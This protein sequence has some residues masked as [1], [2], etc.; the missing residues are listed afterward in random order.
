MCLTTSPIKN[1]KKWNWDGDI[2]VHESIVP[3]CRP[4]IDSRRHY[5]VDVREFLVSERNVVMRRT[6]E[7]DIRQLIIEQQGDAAFFTSRMPGSFDY[8]AAMIAEFVSK[9]IKYER[10]DEIDPWQFPEETLCL[11]SGDCEDRALLL[12]SLML[13]SGIS[14][15]NVRVCLGK[16]R[17]YFKRPDRHLDCDHVWVMYKS[18]NGQWQVIE[19]ANA[20]K[21]NVKE[22]PKD[23]PAQAEYIPYFMFNNTH[24]WQVRRDMAYDA[25]SVRLGKDWSRLHPKFAGQFHK[26]IL[27]DA[28]KG[29]TCPSWAL[30]LLNQHFTGF[31]SFTVDDVDWPD[32]YDPREHFDNGYIAEGW[33]LVN[34]R[35]TQF[36]KDSRANLGEFHKAAHTIADF[37]AH[38][39]YAH[40]SKRNPD[41]SLPIFDPSNPISALKGKP[42][43]DASQQFD[44]T[45]ENLFSVNGTLWKGSH[46]DAAE[47]WAGKI[48]S[49]RYGQRK[50]SKGWIEMTAFIPNNMESAKDFYLRAALPHHNEIAVDGGSKPDEHLLYPKAEFDRQTRLRIDV[51]TRHIRE[52]FNKN[53][54]NLIS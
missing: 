44:L 22:A 32:C 1:W 7:T 6:L 43:Y 46:A 42:V 23:L 29:T 28:L 45:K 2:I 15:Y 12:A 33:D 16:M 47:A 13:C 50:D 26:T 54:G 19:P 49:G 48:I 31:G 3:S 14:P 20:T 5:D 25:K 4:V 37:Y 38:T 17:L 18:E 21:H 36:K 34:Q 41:G 8:R 9:K 39:S 10:N 53:A 11:K 52:A 24:L 40:F 51:A 30:T 35:L 27:N